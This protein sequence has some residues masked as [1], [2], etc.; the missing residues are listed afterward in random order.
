[1]AEGNTRAVC[2][3][4]GINKN[5]LFVYLVREVSNWEGGYGARPSHTCYLCKDTEFTFSLHNIEKEVIAKVDVI[6]ELPP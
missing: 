1:M 4:Q 3:V 6:R 2:P 5:L